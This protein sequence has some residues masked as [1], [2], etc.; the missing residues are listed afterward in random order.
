M[1]VVE[2]YQDLFLAFFEADN[3]PLL[4]TFFNLKPVPIFH[5]LDTFFHVS[6][7]ILIL[8]VL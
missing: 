8:N 5:F 3:P 7:R 2:I 6:Y 4:K 1:L